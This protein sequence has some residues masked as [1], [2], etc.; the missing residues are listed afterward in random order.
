MDNVIL[1]PHVAALTEQ[2]GAAMTREAV[3]QLLTALDGGTPLHVA[4]ADKLQ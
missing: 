1:T 2:C 3:N 4:N